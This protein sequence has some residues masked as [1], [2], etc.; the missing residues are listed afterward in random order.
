MKKD[1]TI[2]SA[3]RLGPAMRPTH[4]GE[5]CPHPF[6]LLSNELYSE[7]VPSLISNSPKGDHLT[8]LTKGAAVIEQNQLAEI[9]FINSS[10]TASMRSGVGGL[11]SLSPTSS[12]S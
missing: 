11:G 2:S 1:A 9:A 5:V 10:T 12:P 3:A 8:W 7:S 4:H 6:L